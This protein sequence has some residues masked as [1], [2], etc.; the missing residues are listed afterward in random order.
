MM[1]VIIVK[2]QGTSKT[3]LT[4]YQNLLI[5]PCTK[6]GKKQ[7][8]LNNFLV[9]ISSTV[10]TK[11]LLDFTWVFSKSLAKNLW[12]NGSNF[13]DFKIAFM[14]WKR[15]KFTNSDGLNNNILEVYE[16]IENI[17]KEVFETDFT[18]IVVLDCLN[19]SAISET[20]Y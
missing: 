10:A 9:K 15:K 17:L 16:Q 11:Y 5:K 20:S 3:R 13:E 6:S 4:R 19:V 8:E 7:H 18:N 2:N 12:N 1:T 14:S